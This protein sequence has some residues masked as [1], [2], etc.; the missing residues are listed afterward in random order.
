MNIEFG[1]KDYQYS[2]GHAPRGRGSW[3]FEIAGETWWAKDPVTGITSMTYGE[4]KKLAVAE[5]KKRGVQ[6]VEVCS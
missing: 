4:A 3:A 1:T 6:E 5:A 2:H